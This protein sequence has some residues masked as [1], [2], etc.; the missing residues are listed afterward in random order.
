MQ[1]APCC[2]P[3]ALGDDCH[4]VVDCAYLGRRKQHGYVEGQRYMAKLRILLSEGSSTSAR[5]A[6]T[7]LHGKGHEVEICDPDWHCLTRFSCLAARFHL[8]PPLRD[9]PA[10]YLAFIEDL[11]KRR[12]FDVLLPVHEQ[13]LLFS[14]VRERLSTLTAIALPSFES[15]WTAVRKSE[16]SR[17]LE[18]ISL[19][20]PPTRV[21]FWAD[22]AALAKYPCVVKSPI[23]TASRGT[24]VLRNPA[25]IL[26]AQAAM[27]ETDV[28]SNEV[29]LQEF[30]RGEVEH[31][32]AVFWNGELIGFHAYRQLRAGA[33]GGD[34]AKESVSRPQVRIDLARIGN[35]LAWH[36][37]L[38]VDYILDPRQ[39]APLYIDCNPRLVEPMN[40]AMAGA[41]LLDLLLAI[42][43]GKRPAPVP[44]GIAGVRTHLG[45]QVLMGQALASGRRRDILRETRNLFTRRGP[46]SESVE[47]LT[48]AGE[49]WPSA[50]PLILTA[51]ILLLRP[52]AARGLQ[53]KSWGTHLLGADTVEF[54]S[55]G[56]L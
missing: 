4:E 35:R 42:S 49:D 54:I 18:E 23:G 44:D 53:R 31:A 14:R 36:G 48:P 2:C 20:R 7:I 22:V 6:L 29:L 12:H 9:D 27:A 8:C 39:L 41:D 13:G 38:S 50:V 32:Q 3:T 16:F 52:R 37:A 19:N 17:L 56:L 1:R 25:D 46:Y 24:A 40:A 21:V 5:E 10:G 26:V 33:G 11:L 34:A 43:L 30:V 47:E 55:R 51:A 15:Y 28:L 45:I